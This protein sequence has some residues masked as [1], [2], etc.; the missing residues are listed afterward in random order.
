MIHIDTNAPTFHLQAGGVSY[1]MSILADRHLV[2]GWRRRGGQKRYGT[3]Y[4]SVPTARNRGYY[5]ADQPRSASRA[6]K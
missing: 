3:R 2:H 1:I 4:P 6:V 5:A